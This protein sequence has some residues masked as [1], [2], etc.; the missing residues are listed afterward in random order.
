MDYNSETDINQ[1]GVVLGGAFPSISSGVPVR[2]ADMYMRKTRTATVAGCC[3]SWVDRVS[4][5]VCV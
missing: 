5:G 3:L 4:R 1:A 2:P